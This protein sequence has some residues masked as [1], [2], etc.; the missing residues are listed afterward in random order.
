M[1]EQ[2]EHGG[3]PYDDWVSNQETCAASK[4]LLLVGNFV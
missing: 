1:A 3:E 2:I 4:Y